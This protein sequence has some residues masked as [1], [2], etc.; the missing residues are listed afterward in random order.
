MKSPAQR[1]RAG[2]WWCEEGGA[3]NSVG[4]ES[5]TRVIWSGAQ[6]SSYLLIGIQK[7]YRGLYVPA[8]GGVRNVRYMLRDTPLA[9]RFVACGPL[10]VFVVA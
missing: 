3:S 4:S 7:I 6:K 2:R 9:R 8:L 10:Y 5:P 1:F